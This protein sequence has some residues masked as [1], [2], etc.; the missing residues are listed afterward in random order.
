MAYLP[1]AVD[2]LDRHRIAAED[3]RAYGRDGYLVVRGLVP[4]S[5]IGDMYGHSDDVL[6]GRVRVPTVEAPP[7]MDDGDLAAF[8]RVHMLHRLDPPSERMFLHPRVLDVVEALIGPDVLALQTMLF[9]NPPGMG[10]QG[11]HQD[12]YYITTYPDTLIGVWLPLETVDEEN[13]CLHVLRG[14]HA[15]PIYAAPEP[16]G[17]V[18]ARGVFRDVAPVQNVSAHDDSENDL[19]P[20]ASKHGS[21]VPV[22]VEPGDA[23]FF[24][25]HLLHRSH[26]NRSANRWRRA[27]VSH[28]SNARSW[29][30]WNHGAP[31]EGEAANDQH[32]L[33]R[34]ATHLAYAAPIFGTPIDAAQEG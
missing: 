23:V 11:W 15:E 17:Y 2:R 14:S 5:D 1:H 19:T 33:A 8:T 22:P 18:H 9:Y 25:G 21:P 12:S 6:H 13:G 10:G 16:E 32:I 24:H 27:F 29:V 31:Y 30:P 20:I 34:G 7:S 4:K 3:Y 28:Y 26:Q